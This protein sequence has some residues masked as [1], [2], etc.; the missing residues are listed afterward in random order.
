[1]IFYENVYNSGDL[2]GV[3]RGDG[4]GS[5]FV[6]KFWGG[7]GLRWHFGRRIG[8]PLLGVDVKVT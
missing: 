4:K 5:A 7:A 1:M 3:G 2:K 8:I 6:R